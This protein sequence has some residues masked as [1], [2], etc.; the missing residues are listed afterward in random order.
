MCAV[1]LAIFWEKL[2]RNRTWLWTDSPTRA[3][4]SIKRLDPACCY[5]QSF[6]WQTDWKH[7]RLARQYT[8]CIL[9]F[10]GTHWLR[11]WLHRSNFLSMKFDIHY[12]LISLT[13]KCTWKYYV[14][15][16]KLILRHILSI[17]RTVCKVCL[18]PS[19]II[20]LVLTNPLLILIMCPSCQPRSQGPNKLRENVLSSSSP[21]SHF[22]LLAVSLFL[23]TVWISNCMELKKAW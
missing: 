7:M 18:C 23:H 13:Q 15:I 2:I 11:P 14:K 6:I 3:P 21:G 4:T 8:A 9:G 10:P 22:W 1:D 16:L 20:V 12:Y 5:S 19:C 17:L